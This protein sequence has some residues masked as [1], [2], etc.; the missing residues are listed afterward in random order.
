MPF[1]EGTVERGTPVA[2]GAKGD[3]LLRRMRVRPVLIVSGD[4]LRY[5]NEVSSV[6]QLPGSGR[7][8]IQ[9]FTSEADLL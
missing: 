9:E 1:I 8:L 4:Q 7:D 2:R 6:G 5:V 3:T